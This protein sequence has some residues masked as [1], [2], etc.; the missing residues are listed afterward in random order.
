MGEQKQQ[1]DIQEV[2]K[3]LEESQIHNFIARDK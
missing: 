3:A 1:M 2:S